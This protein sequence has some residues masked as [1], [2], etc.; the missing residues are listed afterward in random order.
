[1]NR[2]IR[3][4]SDVARQQLGGN[5]GIKPP[6]HLLE[7]TFNSMTKDKNKC[8]CCSIIELIALSLQLSSQTITD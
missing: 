8:R 7:N 3:Y 2:K 1:M 4:H 6:L 5:G